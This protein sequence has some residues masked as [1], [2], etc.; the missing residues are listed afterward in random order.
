MVIFALL[1][2]AP[3]SRT[4]DTVAL[5]HLLVVLHDVRLSHVLDITLYLFC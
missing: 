5:V 4:L 2:A 3:C 1:A